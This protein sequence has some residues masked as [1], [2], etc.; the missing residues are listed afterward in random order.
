M[1]IDKS[2]ST[3]LFIAAGFAWVAI[4]L[5]I[6][7]LLGVVSLNV[8][9]RRGAPSTKPAT[10]EQMVT[11]LVVI[12]PFAVGFTAFG[13]RA[14]RSKHQKEEAHNKALERDV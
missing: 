7:G 12:L 5:V 9:T 4:V 13:L 8:E 11:A 6:L 1:K 14:R 2:N 10:P 3:G